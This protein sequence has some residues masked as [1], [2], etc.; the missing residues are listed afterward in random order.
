MNKNLIERY[1]LHQL[2]EDELALFRGQL[3]FD[4]GLR[5]QVVETK[6]LIKSLQAVANAGAVPP[7]VT[8]QPVAT[9]NSRQFMLRAAAVV[10]GVLLIGSMTYYWSSTNQTGNL[11]TP[12]EQ[13]T[14]PPIA[15]P[16]EENPQPIAADEVE[17]DV[18]ETS[19]TTE[20]TQDKAT[21]SPT[22]S[23]D[24]STLNLDGDENEEE[25]VICSS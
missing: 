11:D 4:E 15:K 16:V 20:P 23:N 19:E 21:L 18:N 2:N 1:V 22:P 8:T 10:V 13:V 3:M 25:R 14:T 17:E 5:K 12:S 9:T 7:K 6:M 24:N